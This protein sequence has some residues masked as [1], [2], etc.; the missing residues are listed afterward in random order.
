MTRED[1]TREDM[2]LLIQAENQLQEINWLFEM[3][4]GLGYQNGKFIHLDNVYEVLRNNSNSYYVEVLPEEE[5]DAVLYAVIE[6]RDMTLEERADLLLSG[7]LTEER[8][9]ELVQ[10]NS[11]YK[12]KDQLTILR[13]EYCKKKK[14]I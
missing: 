8:K 3:I 10:K 5:S 7:D 6:N 1:M 13:K 4:C 12:L 9:E 2:I 14:Y 11:C